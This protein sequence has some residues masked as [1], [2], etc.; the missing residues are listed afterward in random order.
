MLNKLILSGLFGFFATNPIA[1]MNVRAPQT[2]VIRACTVV[3][4]PNSLFVVIPIHSSQ[5]RHPGY[6]FVRVECRPPMLPLAKR[7]RKRRRGTNS[8]GVAQIGALFV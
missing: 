3:E 1:M 2:L 6:R 4:I 8:V 7:H 5:S